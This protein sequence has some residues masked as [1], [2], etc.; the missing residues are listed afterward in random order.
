MGA[1]IVTP[2]FSMVPGEVQVSVTT[3]HLRSLAAAKTLSMTSLR[4]PKPPPRFPFCLTLPDAPSRT[5]PDAAHRGVI[6]KSVGGTLVVQLVSTSLRT[7]KKSRT[8]L[9]AQALA[10]GDGLPNATCATLGISTMVEFV[11]VRATRGPKDGAVWASY[12]AEMTS[13]GMLLAVMSRTALD[14][15]GTCQTAQFERMNWRFGAFL[16]TDSGNVGNARCPA[17]MT[18]SALS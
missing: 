12:C 16:W 17:A 9:W 5:L 3:E 8:M 10:A 7:S 1:K 14:T 6:T 13:V 4:R 2:C 11:S 18:L 15:G